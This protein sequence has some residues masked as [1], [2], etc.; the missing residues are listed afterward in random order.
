MKMR[1]TGDTKWIDALSVVSK[2]IEAAGSGYVEV[3]YTEADE[4]G[5]QFVDAEATLRH[6]L[7]VTCN[8]RVQPDHSGH[9][10]PSGVHA[11]PVKTG[12]V[13]GVN[14]AENAKPPRARAAK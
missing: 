12:A 8:I 14:Q 2:R 5:K 9:K 6:F 1:E 7:E 10:V 3:Y 11:E 13:A 4:G